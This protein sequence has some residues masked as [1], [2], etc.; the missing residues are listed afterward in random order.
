MFHL[1]RDN[2]LIPS[3]L[4]LK[5]AFDHQRASLQDKHKITGE[6]NEFKRPILYFY[7]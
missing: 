4:L 6:F 3:L 5:I 1:L 7:I 2:Y